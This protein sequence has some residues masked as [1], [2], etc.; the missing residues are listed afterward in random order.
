MLAMF[1]RIF[2]GRQPCSILNIVSMCET[3]AYFSFTRGITDSIRNRRGMF[4]GEMSDL[5]MWRGAPPPL[6]A[7]FRTTW[8]ERKGSPL[9]YPIHLR[10]GEQATWR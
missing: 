7:T 10:A 2:L 3:V 4:R 6:M 5:W 8:R 9:P 1:D